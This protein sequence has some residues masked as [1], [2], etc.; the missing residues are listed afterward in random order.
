MSNKSFLKKRICSFK[1]A[2]KG[3]KFILMSQQNAWIHLFATILAVVLG[4]YLKLNNQ[5]WGM[6]VFAMALVWASETFNTALE[7]LTDLV[8]PGYHKLA[9]QAKDLAAG[10][11][12]IA[13][14]AAFIIGILV[15]LPKI[16]NI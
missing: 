14:V 3:I 9:G 4:L 13:A 6:I 2:F 12:L 11:V 1:F 8:S 7:R 15:F 16:F 10:A 5:E